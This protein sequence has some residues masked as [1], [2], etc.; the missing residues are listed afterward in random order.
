MFDVLSDLSWLGFALATL[1]SIALAGLWFPV[2]IAKPYVVALGREEAPAPASNLVTNL[3]PIVC[4]VVVTFT[5]AV[6]LEAL[7]VTSTGDAVLFGLIVGVG[8]LSAMTFQIAIN[9]NFPRPLFYG[10]L[11]APFFVLSSVVSAVIITRT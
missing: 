9:P 8:Y 10:V 6:L 2:L 5:S 11:N 1:A 7:Q 4:L 3:G